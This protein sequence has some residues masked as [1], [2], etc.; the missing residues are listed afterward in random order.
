[1]IGVEK[2]LKKNFKFSLTAINPFMKDFTISKTVTES[3]DFWQENQMDVYVQGLI[4]FRVTYS[5]NYGNKIKKLDRQKEV[6]N[7]GSRSVF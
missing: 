4:T 6:E 2:Q 5:F 3:D 7:D 1:V